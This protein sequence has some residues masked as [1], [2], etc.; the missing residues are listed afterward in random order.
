MFLSKYQSLPCQSARLA[1][2]PESANPSML[3][4]TQHFH[5]PLYFLDYI[6]IYIYIYIYVFMAYVAQYI[7]QAAGVPV[8]CGREVG[9]PPPYS[10]VVKH[11][12]TYFRSELDGY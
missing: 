6:Y 4:L 9:T 1:T 10:V 7:D 12:K 11:K 3:D 8:G 2:L 5:F